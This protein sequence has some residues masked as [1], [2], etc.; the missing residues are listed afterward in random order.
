MRSSAGRIVLAY[1]IPRRRIQYEKFYSSTELEIAVYMHAVTP[2]L[3]SFI[4]HM[5][6]ISM[7][8]V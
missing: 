4:L 5:V 7:K 1:T 6:K 3:K 8:T 2:I